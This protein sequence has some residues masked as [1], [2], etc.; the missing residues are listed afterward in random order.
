MY[1]G[2]DVISLLG[3]VADVGLPVQ[4]AMDGHP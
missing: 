2:P 4:F 1:E 3:D